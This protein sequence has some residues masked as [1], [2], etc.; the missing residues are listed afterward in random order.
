MLPARGPLGP[1]DD[2]SEVLPTI[3]DDLQA[4][5]AAGDKIIV[6]HDEL[7]DRLLGVMGGYLVHAGLVPEGPRATAMIE[8]LVQRQMGPTAREFVGVATRRLAR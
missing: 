5:L 6:H 7:G 2:A 8:R 1:H 4:Q 3:W